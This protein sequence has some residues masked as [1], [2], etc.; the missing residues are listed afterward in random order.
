ML[1]GFLSAA[2]FRDNHENGLLNRPATFAAW[3][4][5]W[6]VSDGMEFLS[7][8]GGVETLDWEFDWVEDV[9]ERMVVVGVTTLALVAE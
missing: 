1:G 8:T 4:A 9:R 3:A 5:A 6:A 7:G 2:G